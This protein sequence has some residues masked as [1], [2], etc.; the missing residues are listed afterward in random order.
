MSCSPAENSDR[1]DHLWSRDQV[2]MAPGDFSYWPFLVDELLS[3][4]FRQA[5]V[6][7][8]L[9]L[10]GWI[11][12]PE[13]RFC[14]AWMSPGVP[15][16]Q[17]CFFSS[18]AREPNISICPRPTQASVF[19]TL[20]TWREESFSLVLMLS[21]TFQGHRSRL[22]SSQVPVITYIHITFAMIINPHTHTM[23]GYLFTRM[24]RKSQI[25]SL[26]EDIFKSSIFHQGKKIKPSK[27]VKI[28]SKGVF[29]E[30]LREFIDL[31][32]SLV[33]AQ[34]W[35]RDFKKFSRTLGGRKSARTTPTKSVRL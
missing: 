27:S 9:L 24:Y 12:K 26:E 32:V 5:C 13:G 14:S 20:L 17:R 22:L 30:L 2:K 3:S 8:C 6:F 15:S 28:S 33:F 31:G 29:W 11:S 18:P 19:S 7:F 4:I 16:T 21:C 25:H 34:N 1:S 10:L 23:S 35:V